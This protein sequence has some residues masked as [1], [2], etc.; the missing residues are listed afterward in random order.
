M[1]PRA[2]IARGVGAPVDH[3]QLLDWRIRESF[4][5]GGRVSGKAVLAAVFGVV[6]DQ[7]R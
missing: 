2:L 6:I 7:Y 3:H 4:D 1:L 5:D